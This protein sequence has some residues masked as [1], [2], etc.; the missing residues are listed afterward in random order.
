MGNALLED[1]RART[2]TGV[3]RMR[4]YYDVVP[5]RE[6]R[7]E[8][9]RGITNE[10]GD[11]MPRI[12]FVDAPESAAL[13]AFTEQSIRGVFDSV[14]GAGGGR[15]LST[16]SSDGQDHPGGGCRMGDD[17]AA[18]NFLTASSNFPSSMSC[19]PATE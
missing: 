11:P 14:V 5:G 3:T 2:R 7:I 13:R 18:S 4:A 8:L 15:I 1:W 6:S 12:D 19:M 16:A 10:W 17:P 9:D